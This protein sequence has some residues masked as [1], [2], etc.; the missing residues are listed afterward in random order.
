[1]P[2]LEEVRDGL[3]ML[4][5]EVGEVQCGRN[6]KKHILDCPGGILYSSYK[7]VKLGDYMIFG[8]NPRGDISEEDYTIAK[9]I[10]YVY[11]KSLNNPNWNAFIDDA[12][13]KSKNPGESKLQ[14]GVRYFATLLMGGDEQLRST[15]CSNIVFIQ[16]ENIGQISFYKLAESCWKVNKYLMLCL[17]IHLV[18]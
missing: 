13:D 18:G 2:S 14:L 7:T 4:L 15:C 16:S 6:I 5:N 3:L 11:E 17:K 10:E 1:M 8:L 9:D 12:W